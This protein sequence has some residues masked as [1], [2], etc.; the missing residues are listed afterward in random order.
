L[1]TTATAAK[2]IVATATQSP[3]T[4]YN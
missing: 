1:F 3:T 4:S 2:K